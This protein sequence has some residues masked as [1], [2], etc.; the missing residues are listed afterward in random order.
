MLNK[1]IKSLL[2]AG[3]VI[4]SMTGA[5]FANEGT[6]S[7]RDTIKTA[8]VITNPDLDGEVK[9]IQ[10]G[11][12]KIKLTEEK[13][14]V[15]DIIDGVCQ[16]VEK[17]Y[18][19]YTVEWDSSVFHIL[20]INFNENNISQTFSGVTGDEWKTCSGEVELRNDGGYSN[21]L[22]SV[23]LTYAVNNT[24]TDG[25]GIPDYK[26][27]TPNGDPEEP[28]DED[29]EEKDPEETYDPETG[30]ASIMPLVATAVLSAAGLFVLNRKDEE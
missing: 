16:D 28:G 26:D 11:F 18:I 3:L 10:S 13:R 25:D 12:I 27:D 5:V 2:V 6:A 24:D 22:E 7:W 21:I 9:E 29:P 15:S 23:Q 19:Q 20:G 8:T 17:T 30:D 1:K 4:M 14:I